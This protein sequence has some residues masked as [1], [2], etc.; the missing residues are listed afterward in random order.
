MVA[1]I[2]DS[3]NSN[4]NINI[5]NIKIHTP[6]TIAS[7]KLDLDSD[8]NNIIRE[9]YSTAEFKSEEIPEENFEKLKKESSEI[10]SVLKISGLNN[11]ENTPTQKK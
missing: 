9:P 1:F 10:K 5:D 3:D 2:F 6:R 4:Y 7:L 11:L 8:S